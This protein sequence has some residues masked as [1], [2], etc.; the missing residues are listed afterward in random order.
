MCNNGNRQRKRRVAISH[1]LTQDNPYE[2]FEKKYPVGT[3]VL[4]TNS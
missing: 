3:I 1:R 4:R 2:L